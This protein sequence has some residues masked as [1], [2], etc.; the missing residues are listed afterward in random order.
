[1]KLKRATWMRF[2][3][4]P[5]H[6]ARTSKVRPRRSIK[7][8]LA[9]WLTV[10]QSWLKKF[11]RETPTPSTFCHL[12]SSTLKAPCN[13]WDRLATPAQ[14][15]TSTVKVYYEPY[16]AA[17]RGRR[18]E[19]SRDQTARRADALART[20]GIPRQLQLTDRFHDF[21]CS[22]ASTGASR[23]CR[24]LRARECRAPQYRFRES[25]LRARGG[26]EI[27][28][29]CSVPQKEE[30]LTFNASRGQMVAFEEKKMPPRARE[31]AALKRIIVLDSAF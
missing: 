7:L 31:R 12:R 4:S 22:R 28:Y 29:Y 14:R 6:R 10:S 3:R 21:R 2:P 1:M 23:R 17:A 8:Y 30:C 16:E 25:G 18:A 5:V 27:T 20:T 24:D 11:H 15:Y 26:S 19:W 9:T 13:T